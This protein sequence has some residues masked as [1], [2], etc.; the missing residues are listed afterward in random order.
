MLEI[1]I[2][3]KCHARVVP[4]KEDTCPACRQG[5]LVSPLI[6]SVPVDHK[7]LDD[8]DTEV[9]CYNSTHRTWNV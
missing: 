8:V 5:W 7:T 1:R 3:P 6:V 4:T 2:C 9:Y